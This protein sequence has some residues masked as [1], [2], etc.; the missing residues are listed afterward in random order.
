M[1]ERASN[2]ARWHGQH[3]VVLQGRSSIRPTSS[4]CTHA[5]MRHFVQGSLSRIRHPQ[6]SRHRHHRHLPRFARPTPESPA[7]P[8]WLSGARLTMRR[9]K[10]RLRVTTPFTGA[11]MSLATPRFSGGS[12]KSCCQHLRA[13]APV[14]P[15][16][17][18]PASPDSTRDLRTCV[19]ERAPKQRLRDAKSAIDHQSGSCNLTRVRPG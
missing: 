3:L 12:A 7:L 18:G 11:S 8:I 10:A 1:G 2:W 13:A 9:R 15:A 5:S 16:A 6:R 4:R 19:P 17:S 14:L